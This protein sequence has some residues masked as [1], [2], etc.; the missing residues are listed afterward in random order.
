MAGKTVYEAEA[1]LATITNFEQRKQA[2]ETDYLKISNFVRELSV[3]YKSDAATVFYQKFDAI[4]KNLSQTETQM[5]SAIN[6]LKKVQE[7]YQLLTDEQK[8]LVDALETDAP[9]AGNIFG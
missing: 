9:A 6:K 8:A 4:Y 1:M 2:F 3:N 5:E 7:I